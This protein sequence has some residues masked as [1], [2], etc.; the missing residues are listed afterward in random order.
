LRYFLDAAYPPTTAAARRQFAL[1][2]TAYGGYVGGPR[3]ANV[4]SHA[5]FERLADI[6]FTFV[7]IYVGRTSPYDRPGAFNYDQG[8]EDGTDACVQTG[9][10]GFNET[11]ILCLD[12]EYGDYQNEPEGFAAYLTGWVEVVNGAGHPAVLYSDPRTIDILGVPE[13]VDWTWGADYVTNGRRYSSPPD[14]QFDPAIPPAWHA[15][16]FADNG[17]IG[18][19][20]CDLNSATDDFPFASFQP[21]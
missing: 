8:K 7:P 15:W 6:G 9:A 17:L 14:G 16:Q 2:W 11:T 4:W 13:L 20:A 10:C 5:A 21:A 12:A 19:A 1:G 3:A 18:G